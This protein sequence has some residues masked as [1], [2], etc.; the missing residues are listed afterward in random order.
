MKT[1]VENAA[2]VEILKGNYKAAASKLAG[3]KGFTAALANILTGNYA[4]AEAAFCKCDCPKN[5]YLKAIIAARKG[6]KEG[7]KTNL[8]NA[9][10][11]ECLAKRAANDI[12]F[13]QFN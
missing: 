8:E 12:E 7:V 10:K 11:C 4:A 1:A 2:T 3:K 13:A 5:A 6:D 9:K